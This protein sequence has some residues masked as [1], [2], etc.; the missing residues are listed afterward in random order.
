LQSP[1][2]GRSAGDTSGTSPIYWD[3][4]NKYARAPKLE[5]SDGRAVFYGY[6]E[7]ILTR[8][9]ITVSERDENLQRKRDLLER[10]FRPAYLKRRKVLDLGSNAGFFCFWAVQNGAD[11]ST[12]VDID[13][14]YLGMVRTAADRL[15]FDNVET[16]KSNVSDW[17]HPADVVLALALVHW[18]YSCTALFGSIDSIVS[19]LAQLT[20]FMLIVEWVDQEDPA[21][22]FFHHTDW[23]KEL[24]RE[25][26]DRA[27]FEDALT[28]HFS[29]HVF[30]GEISP[31]RRLYVAF[32]TSHEIDLSGP[33]PLIMPKRSLISS[34]CLATSNG[35]EYWS[36]VYDQGD[37][38]VKQ[39][40]L[41]LA[42]REAHFL[43]QLTSDY[44]PRVLETRRK[45][46]YSVVVLE[47]IQG[48]PLSKAKEDIN[49]SPDRLHEFVQHCLNLVDELRLRGIVHRDILPE[50][51]IVRN[52]R[53]V[54]LD[55]GWAVSDTS[56]YFAPEGLGNLGRPPDGSF[57]DVYS[58]GRVFDGI[59][60]RR[61]PAFSRVIELMTEPDPSLRIT[62][63]GILKILFASAVEH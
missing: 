46:T 11:R 6:Q 29:R 15:G 20:R 28:R 2:D 44:F 49:A 48:I 16:I 33:L 8:N 41:D 56:P 55:F 32:Q 63:P 47:K 4:P 10:F 23:N 38:I 54:L 52:G 60:E 50:N 18:I 26:Y 25:P 39:T 57:C 1:V 24:V 45:A 34:R 7:F 40:T 14:T 13:D 3:Q 12:A 22:A 21:M 31:T 27:D 51:M 53:P 5:L 9:S 43:S 17:D 30:V 42:L 35:V 61:Y 19:R 37:T 59:N 36:R 58:M 62:D